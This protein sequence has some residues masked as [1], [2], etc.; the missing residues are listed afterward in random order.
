MHKKNNSLDLDVIVGRV[1]S[2]GKAGGG[3]GVG[4]AS[5]PN[6]PASPP[7]ISCISDVIQEMVSN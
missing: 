4:E 7:R 6:S 5:P 3:G 2:T 1:S